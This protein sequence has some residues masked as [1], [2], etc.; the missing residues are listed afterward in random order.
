MLSTTNERE[1]RRS[2][3]GRL[4]ERKG[5]SEKEME[6]E[7][8]SQQNSDGGRGTINSRALLAREIVTKR[9]TNKTSS[10]L[11]T[12]S[13]GQID[14]SVEETK[15]RDATT[16]VLEEPKLEQLRESSPSYRNL[17]W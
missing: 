15:C 9:D 5:A 10:F 1:R 3:T 4:L 11:C 8:I 13:R 12:H 7:R 2:S 6:L 17:Y 16:T 14:K